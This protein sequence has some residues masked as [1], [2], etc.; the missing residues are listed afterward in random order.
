MKSPILDM[1]PSLVF[2]NFLRDC[3][4]INGVDVEL[5]RRSAIG[6]VKYLRKQGDQS[7][8][9]R[10]L[11]KQWYAS[12]DTG[13]P[14]WSVYGDDYYL[15]ELWSCWAVYSRGYMR[16]IRGVS[17]DLGVVYSVVDLGCGFGLTTAAWKEL[18]PEANIIGTN[19]DGIVQ[20][21]LAR[22]NA[23]RHGFQIVSSI[24][25]IEEPIDIIFAS[26]YFEHFQEPIQHLLE[27]VQTLQPRIIFAANAFSARSIGHFK[28]YCLNGHW[29]DGLA[30]SRLFN[31]A[32]R[33]FGYKKVETGFWNNRPTCWMRQ[34]RVV[35]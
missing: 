28:R 1:K 12:L 25:E 31:K 24:N 18:Y 11:E 4:D 14:D 13:K 30:I 29:I 26:E 6:A 34:E 35:E 3:S 9:S 23:D 15:A 21:K 20:T 2:V 19:L 27:I 7:E 16:S 8:A 10:R 33:R 22:L 17:D 5:V 32:A